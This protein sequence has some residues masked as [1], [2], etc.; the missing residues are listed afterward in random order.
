MRSARCPTATADP[1]TLDAF[2]ERSKMAGTVPVV[3]GRA[4]LPKLEVLRAGGL[5]NGGWN[6]D[7]KVRRQSIDAVDLMHGHI[8]GIDVIARGLLRAA[9]LIEQGQLE[10]FRA[11]GGAQSYPSRTKDRINVDF[12]TGSVGLGSAANKAADDLEGVETATDKVAKKSM[13]AGEKLTA[14]VGV[15]SGGAIAFMG[16]QDA[17]E[18]VAKVLDGDLSG[19]NGVIQGMEGM[20]AG[21]TLLIS[22]IPE[23]VTTWVVGHATMA[24]SALAGFAS[25]IAEWAVLAATSLASAAAVAASWLLAVWPVAL[26]IAIVVGLVIGAGIFRLPSLVAEALWLLRRTNSFI[27]S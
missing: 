10:R 2:L 16:F 14:L 5:G 15:A 1:K 26:V 27:L 6:F 25:Q 7:A 22:A 18:G 20:G 24:A 8:G 19:I 17:N 21:M 11:L 12:S 4:A 23:Q 3:L 9:A 13:T